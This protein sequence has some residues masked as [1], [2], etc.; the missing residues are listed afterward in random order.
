MIDVNFALFVNAFVSILSTLS[1]IVISFILEQL[2]NADDPIDFIVCGN[3]NCVGNDE[4]PVNA[5]V[6][7][8]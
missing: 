3:S 1:L 2:E 7:I 5:D 8:V 6:P 4:H